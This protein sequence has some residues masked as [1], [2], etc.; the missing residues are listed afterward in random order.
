LG[1]TWQAVSKEIDTV[2]S[3]NADAIVTNQSTHEKQVF[4]VRRSSEYISE[5]VIDAINTPLSEL[6]NHLAT[7]PKD[8]D[9][10]LHC[11]GG[12]RS[13]IAAS[14]LKSRGYHNL[15][16]IIGGFAAIKKTNTKVTDYLCPSTL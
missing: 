15:I 2:E 3:L 8:D 9:F 7:L 6:N 11:A 10:Y 1:W 5:H 12:Y 13:M 16:N 14:I 4:D